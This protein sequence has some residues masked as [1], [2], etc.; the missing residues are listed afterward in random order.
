MKQKFYPN[1]PI[2]KHL[3]QRI[4]IMDG[5]MGTM[6]QRY[7][8]DEAAYRGERFK[9]HPG[10]LKG[11]N[12]LLSLTQPQI[13]EEIHQAYLEAGADIIETNTFNAN[14]IS[15]RDYGMSDLAYELNLAS[16]RLARQAVDDFTKGNPAKPRFVAGALGPTNRTL[17]LSSKVND[18]GHR[19]VTFDE[20]AEA[21]YQQ[22]RGLVEGGVDLLLVETIFDTLNAKAALFAIENYFDA[23]GKRLPIMLSVTIIDQSGRTLSGQT[24]D[25][26][27]ISMKSYDLLSIGLNCSLGPEQ[28]RPF[29]QELHETTPLYVSLY[30]NAG[31]P[32]AFGEY[33]ESPQQMGKVLRDFAQK[34]WLNLVGGC[35]G[36][37][38]EHIR[39]FA[40]AMQNVPP[41]VLPNI[42]PRSEYSGLEGLTVRPDSNFINIGERCNV[43]GSRRFARLIK[44][45][46]YDEA[47]SVARAQVENG[48]QILDINM[49]EGL[50]DA[51][52]VMTRFLNLMMAEPDIA[53]LPVMIDSSHWETIEAGLKC[54][55]GR[56]IVN[57][58]SLKEGEAR[59]KEQA[60]TALRYGAAVLVMAFDEQGQADTVERRVSVCRR[61]YQI[62]TEEVGFPPEDIIFDPNI[63]AVATGM[64][65]HKNYALDYIEAT[66]RIKA[67]LPLVKISGG[68]S[69][70]SFSFRG[71]EAI[72]QAM[73][74]AFLYHAIQAGMDMGIVNPG[75]I[76][77]YEQIEPELL[78]R[79]E[80]VLFNRRD[81]ATERLTE[82]A[83]SV[84]KQPGEEKR[85]EEWRSLSV[86]ERLAYA[87]V[88]GTADHIEADTAEAL[89]KL[90]DPLLVIEGPLMAGMDRV[91]ELFA[92]GKMFLPQV[93]KS[94][95]VMKKAVAYLTPYLEERRAATASQ[96][97]K[98]LLATV[99]GDVHD[100]GKNIVGVVLG[101]NN[102]DIIDL[103]VMVPAEKI[104]ETALKERVDVVGLSG[105]I[106][107]SLQEMVHVAET[108]KDKK[109]TV[110]LLVGGA[111]TSRKH[112]AVK[113]EPV[114]DGDAVVHV[115]DASR[116]VTV[117]SSLLST[118][119]RSKYIRQIKDEYV[120]IRRRFAEQKKGSALISIEQARS[121]RLRTDWQKADVVRPKKLGVHTFSNYPLQEI[122][123]KIDW[124][125]FFKVWQIKGRFPGLLED[126]KSGKEALRLYE[127][128]REMLQHIIKQQWLEARAVVGL[129]P[130]NSVGD[131]IEI[132]EDESREKV[133]AVIHTLR[134]QLPKRGMVKG[135]R[136]PKQ[137]QHNADHRHSELVSESSQK[138]ANYAN[139]ALADFIAPRQSGISD[140]MGFFVVTA[141][142]G[143]ETLLQRFREDHDEYKSI[144]AK[145]LADRLAEAF[146]ELMHEKIRRDIWGYAPNEHLS[147]ED[148]IREKYRGIRPAPGY[149]A[150]PDHSEKQ[151][152]FNL[153]NAPENSGVSLTESFA[154]IPAA[155]VSGFYFAHP[156]ARYFGV[157]KIG[158]D[159]ARDY[160]RRKGVSLKQVETWLAN[161]LAY[162]PE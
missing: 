127:E 9:D 85:K 89:N 4:L 156:M 150:C 81:D 108:M 37:T 130:A 14:G 66:R 5:A 105:L 54:L 43:T 83:H 139:L 21:Y 52:K 72:R 112:T 91:G 148:L 133:V 40:E 152:L 90:Q 84:K 24:L 56:S 86:E 144:M 143:L 145:A 36:T 35:C 137:V 159:Q 63:F 33:E 123:E 28:M 3:R 55:Q 17:S 107:P 2:H 67:A 46:K 48:A 80:D 57:S 135:E 114:Y 78:S 119:Q 18:P 146:A 50:I 162:E 44:E 49:D 62:L 116:A 69:N 71:N 47:L 113:I 38:P 58:L 120:K 158:R 142:I 140:Y 136:I 131:D 101:C 92:S 42:E 53:R 41:R 19:D 7:N 6:I 77:V 82:M 10:E 29:L 121:N 94:A 64:D 125:P 98:I 73:H 157:G 138:N 26:F 23:C 68:V 141:G 102:Y 16:A 22:A 100:I 126:P 93:V 79:V 118:E 106:T 103:G 96:K 154:M 104:V 88:N 12:D 15:L 27:R 151:T 60:R 31:L 74:S 20:V 160:A 155:S 75:Q 34:G 1:H 97:G 161:N 32:N 132:Y 8:L 61:A 109:I 115:H 87:L 149:P 124:T 128:A 76:I 147:N 51:P 122:S 111:T 99:K 65:E 11:N 129:Y 134:Q 39:F 95:R 70:L 25:A 117:V 153:L 13:I 30:P 59:F 110:P 45:E